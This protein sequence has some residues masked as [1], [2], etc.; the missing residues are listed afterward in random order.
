MPSLGPILP[1]AKPLNLE[2]G[3]FS[4]LLSFTSS[5]SSSE[6]IPETN[7]ICK[8]KFHLPCFFY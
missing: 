5:T 7:E 6:L 1:K 2:L 8:D 4:L 3:K